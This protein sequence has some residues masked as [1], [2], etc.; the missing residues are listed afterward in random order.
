MAEKFNCSYSEIIEIHKLQPN[1]KN[2]NKHPKKQ[3]DMLAKIIDYQGQR[4]PIVV[5]SLSG[6]I[7]K[8]HGRLEAIKRLGWNK[9]A[10]DIQDYENEAQEYADMIAD[11]KIA[12][13]AEHDDSM[14]IDGIKEFKFDDLELLGLDDF[15]IPLE[16]DP[17]KEEIEDDIPTDVETRCKPGDLWI[18]GNHR[19]LCGDSTNIQHVERLMGGEKVDMVFTD[20]PYGVDYEGG[21]KK[22]EKLKDDHVGT[23]I[24]EDVIPIIAQICNGPCYTWYAEIKP[25]GLYNTVNK[26]GDIHALIIWNKNNS[27]FNMN[28]QYKKKHEP[29]LYWKP[30]GKTLLWDGGNKESTVWD[31]NRESRNDYHPTQ[32][33]VELAERAIK[34]H[35]APKVLDL[36]GGSGSTLIACEKTKRKCFMMELDPH[37]CDVILARWENY[38][39]KKAV[40]DGEG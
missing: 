34:N 13:L 35:K 39:G 27:T 10:I 15:D 20:P 12:E 30:K 21:A 9:A 3:I 5:S 36:F 17:A 6:F 31:L 16:A 38:S 28:I 7:V 22:R 14:M 23:S 25:I 29:C 19:L 1:P 8:G 26:C 40:L 33:P 32:K 2:P 37:Y 4:A 11:N 24:Y 18:L